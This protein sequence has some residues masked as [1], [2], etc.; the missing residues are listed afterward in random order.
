[1]I[2]SVGTR[3]LFLPSAF[4]FRKNHFLI[5]STGLRSNQK[6]IRKEHTEAQGQEP[7]EALDKAAKAIKMAHRLVFCDMSANCSAFGLA[8]AS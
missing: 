2:G 5:H 1:M 8:S 6:G 4:R 3:V 7:I